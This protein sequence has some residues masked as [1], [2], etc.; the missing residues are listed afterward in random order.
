MCPSFAHYLNYNNDNKCF[1]IVSSRDQRS[2][3]DVPKEFMAI[4]DK[5]ELLSVTNRFLWVDDFTYKFVTRSGIERLIKFNDKGEFWEENFCFVPKFM[6]EETLQEN[7]YTGMNQAFEAHQI[8]ERLFRKYR[9]YKRN[10]YMREKRTEVEM[11]PKLFSIDY[12]ENECQGRIMLDLSFS[13]LN[14]KIIE[15]LRDGD[16]DLGDIDKSFLKQLCYAILP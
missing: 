2:L 8:E 1:E 4:N 15:Q 12:Y 11:Y 10:Y 5:K 9:I 7:Y 16:L 13:F 6:L 3:F 14:W